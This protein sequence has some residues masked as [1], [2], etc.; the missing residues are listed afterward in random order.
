MAREESNR[1]RHHA[2]VQYNYWF[3]N[4]FQYLN[5]GLYVLSIPRSQPIKEKIALLLNNN[6]IISGNPVGSL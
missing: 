4:Y 6:S 5:R 3:R 1:Y 2:S